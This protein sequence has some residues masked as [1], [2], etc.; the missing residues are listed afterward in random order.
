VSDKWLDRLTGTMNNAM[1]VVTTQADGHRS[2][3][4]VGFSTQVSIN[5]PRLLVA[6]SQTNHTFGVA[7]RS[8]HLA[9]HLLSRDDMALAEL[10][11]GETDDEIDKFDHCAWHSGPQDMPILDNTV[12]WLVGKTLDRI[13]FG[14]HVGYLLQPV[15]AWFAEDDGDLIRLADVIDMDPGHDP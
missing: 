14:D 12:A 8:D 2:G 1:L 4:L 6:I 11:G 15:D 9:V 7:R 13:D 10:F 3:C 5:P